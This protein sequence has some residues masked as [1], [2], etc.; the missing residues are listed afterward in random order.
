MVRS[1]RSQFSQHLPLFAAFQQ[2]EGV[3][4]FNIF[5]YIYFVFYATCVG[6]WFGRVDDGFPKLL[7]FDHSFHDAQTSCAKKT[8]YDRKGFRMDS[9]LTVWRIFYFIFL[10]LILCGIID[11]KYILLWIQI[12]PTIFSPI[13]CD[14]FN[15]VREVLGWGFFSVFLPRFF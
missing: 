1:P 14:I 15:I 6:C 9:N 13:W 5:I 8:L 2:S 4:F 7:Q 10:I 3:I 11:S 12:S